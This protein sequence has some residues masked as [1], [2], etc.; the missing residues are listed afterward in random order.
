MTG[1]PAGQHSSAGGRNGV[2][3]LL[4]AERESVCM[5]NK[6]RHA[7]CC[8]AGFTPSFVLSFFI[9]V[10]QAVLDKSCIDLLR[11]ISH[12]SYV[13]AL[14]KQTGEEVRFWSVGK[15]P[16]LYAYVG[17]SCAGWSA[18]AVYAI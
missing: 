11:N 8:F 17:R 18:V 15:L 7:L 12:V 14:A 1:R 6:V 3:A 9:L 16:D 13:R 10:S 5:A 2:A 4:V